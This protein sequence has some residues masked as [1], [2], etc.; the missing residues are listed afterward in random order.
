MIRGF[1][2]RG[3]T[4]AELMIAVAILTTVVLGGIG[5]FAFVAKAIS[6]SRTKTIATNIAQERME[7][8]K[9]YSYFQLLVTSVTITNTDYE[10]DLIYDNAAYP[11]ETI[12]LWGQP[13]FTRAV[14]VAYVD[15]SGTSISTVSYSSN[16]TGIKQVTVYVLW[17]SGDHKKIEIK[18]LFANPSAAALDSGF[19]GKVT[20]QGSGANLPGAEIKVVGNNNWKDVSDASGDYS[21]EVARG[22]YSLVCS[23]AG[24]FSQTVTNLV[25]SRS[26]MT[27]Q[28]FALVEIGTG[29][30]SGTVWISTNILISQVV[31][32]TGT[33][34]GGEVE[35]VELYNP[36]TYAWTI[37]AS[38]LE[39]RYREKES[40][41]SDETIDL[42]YTNTTLPSQG[43]YLIASASTFTI[44]GV[45][46][47]AD[48]RYTTQA[49][50][51][52][53][54]ADGGII[55][56]KGSSGPIYDRVAWEKDGGPNPPVG[57]RE[58]TV[59]T[60][61]G[62]LNDNEQLIR[63][64]STGTMSSGYGNAYDTDN[65]A[66]N[67]ILSNPINVGP[68]NSSTTQIPVSGQPARTAF[69]FASDGLSN[70][71][72]AQ[73][74]NSGT[75]AEYA[76]FTLTRVA[77]G[78]I[79]VTMIDGPYKA[80][81]TNVS[82]TQGATTRIP[83]NLTTPSW[84]A[85]GYYSSVLKSSTTGGFIQGY[86]YNVSAVPLSGI[87]VEAGGV[88]TRTSSNGFYFLNVAAGA[89]TVNANFNSDNGNYSTDAAVG[90]VTE[91]A[92]SVIPAS[93]YFRLAQAGTITGYVT[94]GSGAL[95]NIVVKAT[96]G[97]LTYE[98]PTDNTGRFYITVS[99]SASYYTVSPVLDPFQTY[100]AAPD[101]S[102]ATVT[103]PG[104]SVFVG[105]FT[106]SGGMGSIS[107]K[108]EHN[109]SAITTGVLI[110][111]SSGTINDPPTSIYGSSAPALSNPLYSV[112]S[113]ADGKY[114]L[115]VRGGTY[116]M[117][118]FY[119]TVNT[120]TGTVSYKTQTKTGVSVTAGQDTPNKDFTGAWP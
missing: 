11:P 100:T 115:A 90:T 18:S 58:T 51:I 70:P 4:L 6:Q 120:E 112:S 111:A 94:S 5:A 95:P 12:T 89:V 13:S 61:T 85:A 33:D 99:T 104:S 8:L 91:G 46:R 49:D 107:G 29:T 47:T 117:R 53:D 36:T 74:V 52:K 84:P 9:N 80:E 48:A 15:M 1:N 30:V 73:V 64:T 66:N 108:V 32:S 69:V 37:N 119:P 19:K 96:L 113:K 72:Q 110:I 75:N 79:T 55:I 65:N 17:K 22:T 2:R 27:T 28:N 105:T 21:F 56:R 14:H 39:L 62:G 109:G 60:L 93:P 76:Q 26:A 43:Y 44:L 24:F 77:T 88:T 57:Y 83:N 23:S 103:A 101:P 114:S 38:N 81:T 71:A 25:A 16:D 98:A 102:T 40:G 92:L 42:T 63:L 41:G 3:V 31:S 82:V 68:R 7:V 78:T 97:S 35:Y 45:V 86:V 54:D 118:A 87:L 116:N 10:P 34:A 59:I 106:V 20:V 67:F 50:K